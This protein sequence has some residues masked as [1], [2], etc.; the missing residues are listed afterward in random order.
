MVDPSPNAPLVVVFHAEEPQVL[1][2]AEA[3]LEHEGIEYLVKR[4]SD[5]VSVVLGHTAAFGGSD[6]AADI[7]VNAVDA[8]RARTVLADLAGHPDAPSGGLSA[9]SEP[10]PAA[11]RSDGPP[12]YR[13][14]EAGSG[15]L[16][17]EISDAQFVILA[18]ELEEESDT[19]S[20]YY[21]DA[22]TIDVLADAGADAD[23]IAMLR[24]ALGSRDGV[25]IEWKKI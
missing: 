6:V 15:A 10:P 2:L 23:L 11:H 13:L 5:R 8:D 25:D 1:P 3:A 21:I 17:G 16:V 14:T 9:T 18:D 24:R 12:R 4:V 20:D 22:A 7:L 19:D